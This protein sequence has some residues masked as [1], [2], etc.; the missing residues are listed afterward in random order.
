MRETNQTHSPSPEELEAILALLDDSTPEV[1]D[2]VADRLAATSGDL[3]EWIASRTTPLPRSTA[4]RLAVLL[5]PAR[6]TVLEADWQVPASG[7]DSL[8]DD[9][10]AVEAL[11][12]L[13]SDFLHDGVTLRQPMSDALDLLAEEAVEA[14][15]GS[16]AALRVWLFDGTRMKVRQ[17]PLRAEFLDI[18]AMAAG[19]EGAAITACL[20]FLLLARRMDFDAEGIL[21]G[22]SACCRIH[23]SGEPWMI[24]PAENGIAVRAHDFMRQT[25]QAFVPA[26]PG[27][28]LVAYLRQLC[29]VLVHEERAE[30]ARLVKRLIQSLV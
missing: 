9:W 10:E 27:D 6:R 15:V 16:A 19:E 5:R 14:R 26:P 13:L 11:L 25:D 8:A 23:Y 12:R 24:L 4:D 3:E 28:L 29:R 17:E 20:L 2:Y 18:A 22:G 1:G 30:D 7:A 21:S